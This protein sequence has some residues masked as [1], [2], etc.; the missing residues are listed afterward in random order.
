MVIPNIVFILYLHQFYSAFCNN[1]FDKME[2]TEI[3]SILETVKKHN[4]PRKRW[5]FLTSIE[6]MLDSRLYVDN[7]LNDLNQVEKTVSDRNCRILDFGT[8]CGIFAILLSKKYKEVYAIDTVDNKSQTDPN[9]KDTPQKQRI[10]WNDL[11]KEFGVKFSHY[12]GLY[13][14]FP[15]NYFDAISTYA[16]LEHVSPEDLD[17]VMKELSRVLKKDGLMFVFKFPR[18]LSYTEHFMKL[19]GFGGHDLLYGDKEG[20]DLFLN[21]GFTIIRNWKSVLLFEYPGL[22]T[23]LIYYPLKI[24][25][26]VFCRFPLD[27][28]SHHNNF[29]L[30]KLRRKV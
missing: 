25:D 26:N 18:K 21:D 8:G 30:K 13:I 7:M 16:V 27:A 20:R 2:N 29:I 14:P 1:R 6:Y 24:L 19:A 5:S 11:E 4:H 12:N 17:I 9:F 23:N 28:L 22:I 3:R 15:D 10:I